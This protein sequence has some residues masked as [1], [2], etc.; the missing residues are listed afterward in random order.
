MRFGQKV[1][2]F[3]GALYVSAPFYSGFIAH[4]RGRIYEF[5]QVLKSPQGAPIVADKADLIFDTPIHQPARF[6]DNFLVW[7]DYQSQDTYIAVSA[8]FNLDNLNSGYVIVGKI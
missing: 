1:Q 8:P 6:G 5:S 2:F 3:E 4:E 7:K